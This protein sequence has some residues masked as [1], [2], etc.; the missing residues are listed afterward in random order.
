MKPTWAQRKAEAVRRLAKLLVD[1]PEVSDT[2]LRDLLRSIYGLGP[3]RADVVGVFGF[4]RAWPIV[5]NYL[6][7]LLAR[8]GLLQPGQERMK[9]YD[10]KRRVF[11][12]QWQALEAANFDDPAEVAANLYLWADEAEK[13]GYAYTR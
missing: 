8:H 3:E 6:W 5:D 4:R 9:D 1:P 11:E 7:R 13:F 12:P 2:E 10:H